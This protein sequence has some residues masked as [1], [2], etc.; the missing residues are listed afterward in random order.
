MDT[1]A[2]QTF[3]S[4]VTAIVLEATPFLL[5]GSLLAGILEVFAAD[6][7]LL[8]FVPRST[9]GQVALGLLAGVV[10]PTC[11]CGVVPVA[12]KLMRKGAPPGVAIPFLLAA[13]V[14]NPVSLLATWVAFRGD[15]PVVGLRV[16]LVAV[17][18]AV[19][20]YGLARSRVDEVLR[21]GSGGGPGA[22]CGH[23]GQDHGHDGQDHG[24][25]CGCEA[26]VRGN[27]VLACLR[28]TAEEF[29][30]MGRFL[31]LGAT[32]SGL[33]KAFFPQ[34][35]LAQLSGSLPLAVAALMLLAFLLSVCSEA[36][37]FVAASLTMFPRAAQLA[38]MALGPMLDLK[39]LP[40]YL[41]VFR[42]RVALA[43][44]VVP[45]VLIYFLALCLG[46]AGV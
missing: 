22:C 30:D 31:I 32:V 43:L 10:L 13:P 41:S 46:L 33:F 4:V 2:L 12:R 21:E 9:W 40:A 27:R 42:R 3:A 44:I 5:L 24:C 25:G 20:G 37:A 6:G 39:L 7:A 35:L 1:V 19:L 34:D 28:H 14:V 18:A 29:L 8:R 23:D 16:L 36:D 38:F 17:P 45:A 11:E 15:F 26:P